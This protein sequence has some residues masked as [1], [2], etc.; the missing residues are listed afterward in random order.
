MSHAHDHANTV[1]RP[2]LAMAFALVLTSLAIAAT[3]SFGLAPHEA[4]PSVERARA[5][6]APAEVRQLRFEDRADGAVVVSDAALG[7]PIATLVGEGDG[8]GFVRGVLRGLARDRHMRGIGAA[9]PF[10]LTRWSD[11]ELTLRDTATGRTI[12]LG[13]FG[14]DNRAAFARFLPGGAA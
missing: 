13:S 12:E 8:G 6:V 14:A 11:G 1:P 4:V 10:A 7:A 3:T 2:A 5:D 9:P